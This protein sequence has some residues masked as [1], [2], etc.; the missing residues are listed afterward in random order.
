MFDLAQN[1]FV[2]I[3]GG[4]LKVDTSGSSDAITS[5]W[6]PFSWKMENGISHLGM[7]RFPN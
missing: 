1:Y 3:D 4:Y 7:S 6:L 5:C 2:G